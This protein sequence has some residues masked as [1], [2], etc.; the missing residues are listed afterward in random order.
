MG[1]H[2]ES[3]TQR[4]A[5][6]KSR[7]IRGTGTLLRRDPTETS[8]NEESTISTK[9]DT[10]ERD[11]STHACKYLVRAAGISWDDIR[12]VRSQAGYAGSGPER[13]LNRRSTKRAHPASTSSA[14][15]L[16]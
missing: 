10:H 3:L 14:K 11:I 6:A 1:A 9:G 4:V 12:G 8:G 15:A 13:V 2:C 16:R 5:D 7:F